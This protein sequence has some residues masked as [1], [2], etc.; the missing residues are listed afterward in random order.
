MN[1]GHRIASADEQTRELHQAFS[2]LAH[3]IREFS[4]VLENL[5]DM[6]QEVSELRESLA[7]LQREFDFIRSGLPGLARVEELQ[8]FAEK[9]DAIPFERLA[10]K[11]DV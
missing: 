8:R 1:L 10:T 5:D 11:R 6:H 7:S 4:A 2:D 3:R 9:L